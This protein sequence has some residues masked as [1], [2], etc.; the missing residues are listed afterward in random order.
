MF[1]KL[2]DLSFQ[3]N[4][5][6]AVGFYL[7]A[8][9]AGAVLLVVVGNTYLFIIG[10][11]ILPNP[12]DRNDVIN[13]MNAV[14]PAI[15]AT[16]LLLSVGLSALIVKAKKAARNWTAIGCIFTAAV[17]SIVGAPFSLIPVAYLTTLPKSSS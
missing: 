4:W 6:Q 9:L 12:K 5:K 7:V 15:V 10:H 1:E 17:L 14:R 8:L 3:R 2:T 13:T 11:G 16:L